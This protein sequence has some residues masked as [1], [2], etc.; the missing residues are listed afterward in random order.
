MADWLLAHQPQI[1]TYSWIGALAIAACWEALA[2]RR[3]PGASQ[4]RWR[5]NVALAIAGMLLIW[6]CVPIAG[7][8]CANWV[9]QRGIGL[10]NVVVLPA[11]IAVVLGVV[12]LDATWYAM[13]RLFHASALLWRFHQTHHSDLEIDSGT[14][15]RHHPGEVAVVT[16]VELATIVIAGVPAAAVL[17][18]TTLNVIV[19]FLN[20][21]NVR[22]PTGAERALRLLV[23]TPD[24]H[25]IHHSAEHAETN[26]N[27]S[28][29]MPWWDRLFGTF[30]A[31]PRLGHEAIEFGVREAGGARAA[32]EPSLWTLLALP[33]HPAAPPSRNATASAA[34][35]R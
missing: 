17:A 34:A 19:S 1:Q 11:W 23:V 20:H 4:R 21:G 25:R 5:N 26:S 28:A 8:E 2:P 31:Q 10:L 32:A 9:A 22:L 35:D 15:L 24:M 12:V 16:V 29:V 14:N 27:Y 33:L 13:H 6:V 30:T 18:W 7:I 3:A